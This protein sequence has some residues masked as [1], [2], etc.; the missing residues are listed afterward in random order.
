MLTFLRGWALLPYLGIRDYGDHP[1]IVL[2]L[3]LL[4]NACA[5]AWS[6]VLS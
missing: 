4:K 2:I 3:Q 6:R 1:M 5:N